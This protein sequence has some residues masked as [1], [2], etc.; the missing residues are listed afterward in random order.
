MTSYQELLAQKKA[1][2]EAISAA[3]ATE[4]AAKVAE[5][6]QIIAEFNLTAQDIFPQRTKGAKGTKVAAKYR[7]PVTGKAW[8]GRGVQPKWLDGKNREDYLVG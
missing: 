3:R 8:S 4:V 2:D 1:L 7:D 6:K 5:I